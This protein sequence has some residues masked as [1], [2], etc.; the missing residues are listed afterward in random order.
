MSA[1][2]GHN[3][4]KSK[5]RTSNPI[6][7]NIRCSKNVHIADFVSSLPMTTLIKS[8]QT[9]SGFFLQHL[10]CVMLTRSANN[11]LPKKHLASAL[12]SIL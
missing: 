3:P 11:R 7:L 2:L 4:F 1:V 8:F 6:I 9:R 5:K 10:K 12:I